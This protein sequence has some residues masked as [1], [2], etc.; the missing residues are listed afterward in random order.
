MQITLSSVYGKA[1]KEEV[2]SIEEAVKFHNHF[3]DEN[4]FGSSE[5][6]AQHGRVTLNGKTIAVVHYNGSVT[7][8]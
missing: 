4:G 1:I 5:L 2:V 7:M 3:I 6:K 8:K